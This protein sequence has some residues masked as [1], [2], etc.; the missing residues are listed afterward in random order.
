MIRIVYILPFIFLFA[1][2]R[3]SDLTLD[4]N[5]NGSDDPV[6]FINGN[7]SVALINNL[8]AGVNNYY[9]YSDYGKSNIG[10]IVYLSSQL[11]KSGTPINSPNN[12]QIELSSYTYDTVNF[13][14]D[15]MFYVGKSFN[16][17]Y[18]STLVDDFTGD[19]NEVIIRYY[20][21]F[22]TKY[23]SKFIPSGF[24][25][26][27]FQVSAVEDYENNELGQKVKRVL[28]F[29]SCAVQDS[30]QQFIDTVTFEGAFA[31][32]YPD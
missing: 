25:N 19:T 32:A 8:S 12:I 13:D 17:I 3:E 11:R 31:F 15:A 24:G 29:A 27:F 14:P 23:S 7:S 4:P 30:S 6:F 5:I 18:D 10:Q 2:N 9:M 1:C 21:P 26:T 20:D 28:F 16:F 22:G